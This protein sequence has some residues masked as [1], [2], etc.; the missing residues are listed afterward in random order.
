MFIYQLVYLLYKKWYIRPKIPDLDVATA[1]D[2]DVRKISEKSVPIT[3][4]V[5]DSW[6]LDTA[7]ENTDS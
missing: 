3:T 1:L 4:L 7:L 2:L 6:M 5:D